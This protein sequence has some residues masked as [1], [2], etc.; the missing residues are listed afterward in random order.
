MNDMHL[1]GNGSPATMNERKILKDACMEIERARSISEDQKRAL[2]NTFEKRFQQA[3][4]IAGSGRVRKYH[5][6]P[7]GRTVW[8]VN[9]RGRD[10]Q[11]MPDSLFCTCDDYYFR[12]MEHKKQLCYH[13][14][15]Q[16]LCQAMNTYRVTETIDSRYPEIISKLSATGPR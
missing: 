6:I 7:S 4:V 8:A 14:L 15:A 9:G 2:A 16:Q 5:F 13:I 3:F 12:V 10:Y 1:Q 11:V